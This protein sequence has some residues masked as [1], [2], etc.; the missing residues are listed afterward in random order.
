MD[1]KITLATVKSFIK[2]NRAHLLIK[3]SSSFDGMTDCVMPVESEF[4][5]AL[6]PDE[7][8]NFKETLGIHG[9]WFVFG[10]R[11]YFY[12]FEQDGLVGYRVSNCCGSFTLAIKGGAL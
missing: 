11:D 5:P 6:Q 7:G 3:K 10:S 2:K 9:A 4:T 12:P 1:K 8:R